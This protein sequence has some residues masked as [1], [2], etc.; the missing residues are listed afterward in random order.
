M[1]T[2]IRNECPVCRATVVY[3]GSTSHVVNVFAPNGQ[4]VELFSSPA[5]RNLC[6]FC[7]SKFSLW[8]DEYGDHR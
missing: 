5:Y 3:L 8:V 7:R 1:N 4:R 6:G 2:T